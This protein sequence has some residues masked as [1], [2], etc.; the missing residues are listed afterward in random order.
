MDGDQ[1][2]VSVCSPVTP[3][4]SPP[5]SLPPPGGGGD[6]LASFSLDGRRTKSTIPLKG[7][8]HYLHA[9]VHVH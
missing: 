3:P 6:E 4:L 1:P 5:P 7:T 8:I 9:P 2:P